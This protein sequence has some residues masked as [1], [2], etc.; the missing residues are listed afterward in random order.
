MNSIVLPLLVTVGVL[1]G[2]IAP[3]SA[4]AQSDDGKALFEKHCSACHNFDGH[5]GIGLPL[6]H[7]TLSSV[8][9]E[10]LQRTIRVGRVGRIMPAFGQL[11]DAE[12]DAIVAYLRHLTGPSMAVLPASVADGDAERGR[13]LFSTRCSACHGADGRGAEMG[14]GVTLSRDRAFTV[15][16]PAIVNPGFL[17]S[18][19]DPL[20]VA[21]ILNGRPGT[22]MPPFARLGLDEQDAA[23]LVAYLRLE[24]QRGV[25]KTAL[26]PLDPQDPDSL[27]HIIESSYDLETTVANIKRALKGYNFRSFPDR[28]LQQGLAE[29]DAVDAKQI[30][31]R[32]CNFNRLYDLLRVEPRLGVVLPCRI[33]VIEDADGRVMLYAQNLR[34]VATWFNNSELSGFFSDMDD[35]L[36]EILEEAT[37]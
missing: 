24:G 35:S 5:G 14:T 12:V 25:E 3:L 37:L 31:L 18:A 19:S 16:P 26:S 23:D 34:T 33:T 8:T 4:D 20:L 6:T 15:A 10:Y 9:D 22:V 2:I 7:A 27:T 32:F 1:F 29:I 13:T 30:A 28:K 17:S 11:N 36:L 21:T